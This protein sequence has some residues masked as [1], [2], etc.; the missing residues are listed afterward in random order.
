[1][2]IDLRS[3]PQPEDAQY[4]KEVHAS[5]ILERGLSERHFDL[6]VKHFESTMKELGHIIPADKVS[7]LDSFK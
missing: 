7:C 2:A 1:M 3:T 6:F 5:A 4:L